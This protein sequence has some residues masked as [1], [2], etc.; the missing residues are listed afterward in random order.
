MTNEEFFKSLDE[1]GFDEAE[2]IEAEACK[3]LCGGWSKETAGQFIQTFMELRRG[4]CPEA[5]V[6]GVIETT[7]KYGLSVIRRA[8][9]LDGCKPKTTKRKSKLSGAGV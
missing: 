2:A 5:S 8:T 3:S 9:G 6:E 4:A 1:A 7:F